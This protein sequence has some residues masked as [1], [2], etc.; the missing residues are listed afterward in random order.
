MAWSASAFGATEIERLAAE[1]TAD[2]LPDRAVVVIESIGDLLNSDAD[3][4]LQDF[5]RAC[6]SVG[7][8]VIA[9]G[10]TSSVTGSWPLLQAVKASRSGIVLQPDQMDGETLFKT[11]FPRTTRVEFPVGRGLMAYAGAVR[12]VQVALPE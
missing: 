8:F 6:R 7:A 5:V 12:K 11:P 4:S 9:E 1:L 10:E 2:E 3:L